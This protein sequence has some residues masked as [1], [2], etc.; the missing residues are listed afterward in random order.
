VLTCFQ[1]WYPQISL[2]PVMQGHIVQ[3]EEAT[4]V[5]VQV[6]SNLIAAGFECHPKDA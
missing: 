4:K 1:N 5:G 3:M 2:E 6:A